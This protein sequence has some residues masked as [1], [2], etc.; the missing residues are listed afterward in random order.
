MLAASLTAGI[1]GAIMREIKKITVVN[2]QGATA[3]EIGYIVNGLEI[4]EIIDCSAELPERLE[5]GYRFFSSNRRSCTK[6]LIVEIWN[7]PVV[8]E[9]YE[10]EE[11][12]S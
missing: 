12:Q 5:I 1:G 8:V 7:A 10:K 6:D 2:Q 11:V 4:K 9:Y 3:Y